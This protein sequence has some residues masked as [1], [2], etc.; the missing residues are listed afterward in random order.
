VRAVLDFHGPAVARLVEALRRH[1]GE[2]ALRDVVREEGVGGVLLL[3]DLHP[4]A[5]EAIAPGGSPA[6]P[7]PGFVPV[8]RLHRR[9]ER[10]AHGS[11]TERCEL[12][13][14]VV[15]A[16]HDHLVDPRAR[17]LKC[18]CGACATL[19]TGDS[20]RWKRVLRRAERLAE[21]R[22]SDTAWDGLGIP[23]RLAFFFRSSVT[24]RVAAFYPGPAGAT[25]SLLG[26]DAWGRIE[27][28]NPSLRSL[29][30]DV[31]ALLV[32]RN[33]NGGEHYVVSIDLCYELV[34]LIRRHWHGLSGGSEA[35]GRIDSFFADL[36]RAGQEVARA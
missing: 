3:H 15:G 24:E 29:A 8:A 1:G 17:E 27:G 36:A 10:A 4:G 23:I 12:C 6:R 31:E 18:A 16:T 30:P 22:L 5:N 7:E 13:G 20:Q 28:D 2:D 34:G 11:E 35:W 14:A 21:F 25:E 19:F 26:L 33:A 32:R 9:T